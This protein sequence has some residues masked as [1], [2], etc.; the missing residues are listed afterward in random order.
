MGPGNTSS[1]RRRV[2]GACE[3]TLYVVCVVVQ[4]VSQVTDVLIHRHVSKES[5]DY[6]DYG[7]EQDDSGCVFALNLSDPECLEWTNLG[8]GEGMV[9]RNMLYHSAN[10]YAAQS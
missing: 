9:P 1:C 4:S 3:F 7:L 8:K 2:Q 10:S 5:K 6:D